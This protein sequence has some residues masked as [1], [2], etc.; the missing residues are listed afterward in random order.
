MI[1][2]HDALEK[3]IRATIR[4]RFVHLV[5]VGSLALLTLVMFFNSDSLGWFATNREVEAVEM[6]VESPLEDLNAKFWIYSYDE[7]TGTAQYSAELTGIQLTPFDTVFTQRNKFTPL[8][9]L[10]EVYG[11]K[12]TENDTLCFTISRKGPADILPK[13]DASSSSLLRFTA[14]AGNSLYSSDPKVLYMNL[15]TLLYDKTKAYLGPQNGEAPD[16]NG[17]M[18]GTSNVFVIKESDTRFQKSDAIT[19]Q[20]PYSQDMLFPGQWDGQEKPCLRAYLYLSYDEP[21]LI[22]NFLQTAGPGS[23]DTQDG[24][25]NQIKVENDFSTVMISA[26]KTGA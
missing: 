7:K 18:I 3:E 4:G 10:T 19:V 21:V 2:D 26:L 16:A 24:A 25:L 13:L 1:S 8:I 17:S 20:V 22:P 12:L 23:L 5:I 11:Q 6:D 9:I 14:A 15:Y